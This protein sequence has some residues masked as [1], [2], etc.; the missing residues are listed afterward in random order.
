[1][2]KCGCRLLAADALLEGRGRI[3]MVGIVLIERLVLI[4][5]IV[6]IERLAG[7]EE[8]RA[9][10]P[11]NGFSPGNLLLQQQQQWLADVAGRCSTRAAPH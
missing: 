3:L 1:M 6:L 4:E 10:L 7:V 2:R 5:G 9:L 11:R 8:A